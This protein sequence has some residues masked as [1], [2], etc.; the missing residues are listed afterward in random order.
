MLLVFEF[1]SRFLSLNRTDN[2]IKN[3]W[4]SSI[5]KK[6]E[7]HLAAIQGVHEAQIPTS[8]DGRYQFYDSVDSM[9]SA[10]RA[11]DPPSSNRK[12]RP[13]NKPVAPYP[14]MARMYPSNQGQSRPGMPHEHTSSQFSSPYAKSPMAQPHAVGA[15]I[16]QQLLT[17]RK[18]IFDTY[19]P[20]DLDQEGQE[21]AMKMAS[22]QLKES[23]TPMPLSRDSAFDT[24]IFSPEPNAGLNKTLFSEG[25]LTPFPKTPKLRP[26]PTEDNKS[27]SPIV[28]FRLGALSSPGFQERLVFNRVSV[29]PVSSRVVGEESLY[30]QPEFQILRSLHE[31]SEHQ[32]F[33]VHGPQSATPG[34]TLHESRLPPMSIDASRLLKDIATPKTDATAAM[35]D[36]SFF[37]DDMSPM[38][39]HLTPHMPSYSVK[40]NAPTTVSLSV[41]RMKREPM[42]EE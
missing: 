14:A 10:I 35:G 37:I 1:H 8:D 9:M 26:R 41:K 18:S 40:R 34:R 31:G 27:N 30:D 4:N 28:H 36:D 11:Q 19:S 13:F 25:L 29:S 15:G 21:S 5:K 12:I 7:R 6:V 24:S 20:S 39:L 23:S 38:P 33:D 22:P 2:A 32:E 3:H 16:D 17:A 42:P